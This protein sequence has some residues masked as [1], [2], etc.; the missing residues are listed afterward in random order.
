MHVVGG[1]GQRAYTVATLGLESDERRAVRSALALSEHGVPTFRSFVPATTRGPHIV[2][3]N[4]DSPEAIRMW[5]RRERSAR[6]Q[7]SCAIFL[8]RLPDTRRERYVL[9][10]P[11][12]PLLL[13]ALL[14]H[15]V[16]KH[17]GFVPPGRW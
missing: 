3:V 12:L 9:A 15:V 1:R 4:G 8:T 7:D 2:I 14:E 11:P 5:R 6:N 10:R 13:L 17:H 16:V